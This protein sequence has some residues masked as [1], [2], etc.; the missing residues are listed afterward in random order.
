MPATKSQPH[1]AVVSALA[2]CYHDPLLYVQIAYPWGQPG[3]ALADHPGPDDWQCELLEEVGEWSRSG[4]PVSGRWARA[5]GHGTGK[6]AVS[7]WLIDWFTQTRPHCAGVVTANTQAQL[8]SKTWRELS[9]WHQRSRF[10]DLVEWTATRYFHKSSPETWG[11]DAIPW[12]DANP[13]AF[14]GLHADHVLVI[15]DEASAI[16][17]A[18]WE[19]SEGAMTTPGAY[20][21]AWGNPTRNT[22]K[23]RQCFGLNRDQWHAKQID[24]RTCRMPNKAEI[25]QW[26][27]T[28]GEDSDFFRIRVKGQFPS[29]STDQ[30]IGSDIVTEAVLREHDVHVGQAKILSVDVARFGANKSVASLRQGL[31]LWPQYSWSGLD[32]M[33]LAARVVELIRQHAPGQVMVD[34]TGLGAGVVDRIRQMGYPVI[35]VNAGDKADDETLYVNKRT[36]MWGRMRDWLRTADI[37]NTPE[38]IDDL[39]APTYS[40]DGRQRYRLERKE[41]MMRRGIA[42]PDFGDSLAIGFAY[43][44]Q[45][46]AMS[47]ADMMPDEDPGY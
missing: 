46:V 32:T 25:Q 43:N 14:A 39:I 38:L 8:K 6:T 44:V 1:P 36:E 34:E 21:F 33:Q 23:F 15:Y 17:D 26:A 35:G 47:T 40:F 11:I 2:Q 29:A 5:T 28:Y 30:F 22:G 7:A 3:T 12:S 31:K 9:I 10:R 13:E 18:I 41:E 27:D 42:S 24:A 16:S 37:P 20:W 45:P 4:K 19:V